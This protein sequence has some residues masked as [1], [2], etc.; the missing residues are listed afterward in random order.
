MEFGQKT[1]PG[2]RA[3]YQPCS[4]SEVTPLN[5]SSER[6]VAAVFCQ[7][8]KEVC[9][10]LPTLSCLVPPHEQE[11]KL[12]EP[13]GGGIGKGGWP[14]GHVS[15]ALQGQFTSVRHF[16][17]RLPPPPDGVSHWLPPS[18]SRLPPS[19]VKLLI[20]KMVDRP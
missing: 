6:P 17:G 14:I 20:R 5:L 18:A 16:T 2:T 1:L 10:Q 7:E 3:N 8:G 15:L 9:P 19:L 12:E 11:P 4:L 13:C